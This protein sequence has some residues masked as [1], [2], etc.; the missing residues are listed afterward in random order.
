MT[1]VPLNRCTACGISRHMYLLKESPG[2][3]GKVCKDE[4]ACQQRREKARAAGAVK[5][6]R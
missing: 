6:A 2:H 3:K 5:E 1:I 4:R